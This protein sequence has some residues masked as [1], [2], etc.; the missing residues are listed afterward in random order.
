MIHN[1]HELIETQKNFAVIFQLVLIPAHDIYPLQY[2]RAK[3]S[4]ALGIL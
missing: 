3:S 2:A 1:R 4:E